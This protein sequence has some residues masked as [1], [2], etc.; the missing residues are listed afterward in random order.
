VNEPIASTPSSNP[1]VQV[2]LLFTHDGCSVY[3][4][5]DGTYHYYVRCEG[6]VPGSLCRDPLVPRQRLRLRRHHPDVPRR[7]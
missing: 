5:H 6:R 4:F 1:D 2:D 7:R 3:R